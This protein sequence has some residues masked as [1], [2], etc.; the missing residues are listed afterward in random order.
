MKKFLLFAG[1]TFLCVQLSA[2][3]GNP[4]YAVQYGYARN[5]RPEGSSGTW[6]PRKVDIPDIYG[7]RTLKADL[8]THTCL[9]DGYVNPEYRVYEAWLDGLD[10]LCISDHMPQLKVEDANQPF[11]E[12]ERAA[13][14][15]GI[16]LIRGLEFSA[17]DPIGHINI[18][19][20]E[21]CN[22]YWCSKPGNEYF[23]DRKFT[24][25]VLPAGD[26]EIKTDLVPQF[27]GGGRVQL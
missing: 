9:S 7:Y 18:L 23:N 2:Q 27:V 24:D 10:V 13:A 25:S 14:E 26:T 3:Q 5:A 17:L 8:H 11:K 6:N 15:R 19:F 1:M 20:V 22:R 12:G 21:D 16:T 4:D